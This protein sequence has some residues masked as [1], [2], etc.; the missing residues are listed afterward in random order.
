MTG[1]GPQ[2]GVPSR[3]RGSTLGVC[4]S[5][6]FPFA[7]SLA[8]WLPLPPPTSPRRCPPPGVT[9][10]LRT[11]LVF[12]W[13]H[14]DNLG[15]PAGLGGAR[16][17]SGSPSPA[18]SIPSLR[19]FHPPPDHRPGPVL[20]VPA[21]GVR[22]CPHTASFC[23]NG[24]PL[25]H[26][27]PPS[28]STWGAPGHTAPYPQPRLGTCGSHRLSHQALTIWGAPGPGLSAR[29]PVPFFL[30]PRGC[31]GLLTPGLPPVAWCLP[32]PWTPVWAEPR[33]PT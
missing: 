5:R 31:P 2:V 14:G 9:T 33:P 29:C 32:A 23:R 19:R 11:P 26:P 10:S 20:S 27:L 22:P 1:P 3:C 8:S 13:L 28:P 18:W 16:G 17:P 21:C 25:C 15:G 30:R 6:A 7:R 4:P 24:G 12:P